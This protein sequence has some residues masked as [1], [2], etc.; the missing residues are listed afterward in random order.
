VVNIKGGRAPHLSRGENLT[1]LIPKLPCPI[2]VFY[3]AAFQRLESSRHFLT[4]LES[5]RQLRVLTNGSALRILCP[6]LERPFP[7]LQVNWLA[8]WL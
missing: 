3:L 7:L 6:G 4:G 5:S 1:R 2:D 8:S